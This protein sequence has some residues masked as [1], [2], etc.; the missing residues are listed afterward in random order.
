LGIRSSYF[1]LIPDSFPVH[2]VS[3]LEVPCSHS[4]ESLMVYSMHGDS[5][6]GV[7]NYNVYK[8]RHG[9]FFLA[10]AILNFQYTVSSDSISDV[11]NTV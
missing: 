1:H 10:I 5:F 8:Q 7:D 9:D 11:S 3:V 2:E 6:G 4:I